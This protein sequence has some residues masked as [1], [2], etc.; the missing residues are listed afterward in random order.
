M[1]EILTKQE[2]HDLATLSGINIPRVNEWLQKSSFNTHDPWD[3]YHPIHLLTAHINAQLSPY[4]KIVN[5]LNVQLDNCQR[6]RK[7]KEN[8]KKLVNEHLEQKLE[9]RAEE[10]LKLVSGR[11]IEEIV[12]DKK[13]LKK[14]LAL[15]V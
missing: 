3:T 15:K 7:D 6:E 2:L 9:E 13:L 12:K 5:K 10:V 1:K 8:L 14:L 11:T 4:R